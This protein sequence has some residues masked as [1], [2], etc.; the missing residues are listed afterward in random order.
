MKNRVLISKPLFHLFESRD[1]QQKERIWERE[2][3]F[4]F[5]KYAPSAYPA[6]TSAQGPWGRIKKYYPYIY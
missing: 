3:T 5:N 4:S 1:S 2:L 6:P